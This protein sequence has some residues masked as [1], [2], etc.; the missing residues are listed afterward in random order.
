MKRSAKVVLG[1]AAV[2]AACLLA[3]HWAMANGGP[4]VIKYPGGDPAAK[5]TLARLDENLK[6]GRISDLR[7]VKEEL[8]VVF[9]RNSFGAPRGSNADNPPLANVAAI[10]T[11]ESKTDKETSVDFGFPILRGVAISPFSMS[12]TPDV[13]VRLNGTRVLSHIISNSTIYGIIR[14]QAREA[15]EKGAFGPD[16]QQAAQAQT[17]QQQA[18]TKKAGPQGMPRLAALVAAVRSTSGNDREKAR[19]AL[20]EYLTGQMKWEARDAALMVEYAG[21]DLGKMRSHPI[22]R[23]PFSVFMR[24]G[25][26]PKDEN[27]GP[28]SAIGEQKAT[29]MLAVLAAKF[30]PKAAAAYEAIFTAWGGDVREQSVDLKT[31]KVR[32]R[33]FTVAQPAEGAPA[34]MGNGDPAVYARVNYLDPNAKISDEERGACSRI[35]KNLPVV[36]TFAPMNLL[37]YQV[38]FPAR[39]SANDATQA[40]KE[41]H[42]LAVDYSQYAYQDTAD[43]ESYQLAYVLHPASM[44]DEFGPIHLKVYAP[45][46]V[47]VTASV[48]VRRTGDINEDE[49]RTKMPRLIFHGEKPR[50]I[51]YEATLTEKTGEL[52]VAVD[53]AAWKKAMGADQPAAAT[54]DNKAAP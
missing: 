9:S 26:D 54:T 4:F 2:A 34:F 11:I 15:I 1:A 28:L 22:D 16:W 52:F 23:D 33:E 25:Q 46:G 36:F 49:L 41:S 19:Q 24:D 12:L 17:M 39:P 42:V 45:E 27:L 30:D 47:P 20:G 32:P 43:P 37:H 29:Q 35:L 21:L 6:P 13:Y 50:L 51:E 14:R 31:G 48:P 7:V 18:Y 44:W 38:K 40:G 53:A 5:G 8:I 3:A 10:Y